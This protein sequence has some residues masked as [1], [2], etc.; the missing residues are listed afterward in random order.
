MIP[1]VVS[2]YSFRGSIIK[3]DALIDH[4][5]E[6]GLRSA[7]LAD[8]NFHGAV[9]FNHA[10]RE[11]GKIPIHALIKGKKVF[12]A[13]NREGF[14]SLVRFYNGVSKNMKSVVVKDI[15]S[16]KVV[17][18]LLKEH[19][20][21][22]ET[23]RKILKL[24]PIEGDFSM[25]GNMRDPLDIFKIEDYSLEVGQVFKSPD[26]PWPERRFSDPNY[27]KR[28]KRELDVVKRMGLTGYFHAVERIVRKAREMDV[29]V[30]PGR[31]SAVGSLLVY[32][33]GIT[34]V[35]PMKYG[36]M[37][38]RFLNE[39]RKEMPDIDI[40]IE[41]TKRH[42]LIKSLRD[43]FG[44]VALVS[45]FATLKEKSLR[46]AMKSLKLTQRGVELVRGL[47][48]KRS[49]HAAGVVVSEKPLDLP[50]IKAEIPIIEYDMDSLK[51]IGVEKIDLLG[52][53]TLSLLRE[54]EEITGENVENVIPERRVFESI[55][56][57]LTTGVFQLESL[58]AREIARYVMPSSIS[59]LSHLLAFNRPGPLKIKA[60][61]EYLMH[62][63]GK[64]VDLPS[65]L[66][67][68]LGET[69]GLP[70]YQEQITTMVS[71]LAGFSLE[72]A[73]DI[74]RAIS[75]KDKALLSELLPELERR[76]SKRYDEN[77]VRITLDLIEKFASYAFNKSHSVAYAHMSYWM[78]Y[79]K[80]HHFSE[81]FLAYLRWNRSDVMKCFQIVQEAR[82]RGY[83]VR[84]PDINSPNGGIGGET[85]KLPI[86]LIKG[87]GGSVVKTLEKITPIERLS[88][89]KFL[90]PSV[91]ENLIKSGA[92]DSIY[93]S[94]REALEILRKGEGAKV[95]E[96]LKSKMG[97]LNEKRKEE[98]LVDR[99]LM[100][101]DVLGF[102]VTILKFSSKLPTLSEVFAKGIKRAVHVLSL[103]KLISDG[104]TTVL[105]KRPLG[106]GERLI[107][108]KPSGDVEKNVIFHD[109]LRVFYELDLNVENFEKILEAGF[110]MENVK[111]G[112]KVIERSRPKIET[113]IAFG[114][115]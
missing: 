102:P 81:F 115:I 44:F 57:G 32:A 35:D 40:D 43:V 60:H 106:D 89:L 19:R 50:L 59:E 38:E 99:I 105:M 62:R 83:D 108:M 52:L 68:I 111:V 100:E 113:E 34:S 114:K 39:G 94:R 41:D 73:D 20:V 98:S 15:S 65:E 10:M 3:F 37:F 13:L 72:E 1:L 95:M 93:G 4:L 91:V 61:R 85:L 86:W 5:D 97:I 12:L 53:R 75:K 67:E 2:P 33:L 24:K 84:P 82:Y 29:K 71:K 92:L 6:L 88:D 22:F 74:R 64:K 36:L 103:G 101:S 23:M 58:E 70:V 28:L 80:E 47:P 18:Y 112:K 51:K 42:D 110:D 49:V 30:G 16:F 104:R 11:R 27:V 25:E 8:L 9:E 54:L 46:N 48:F 79:F 76:L 66:M 56:A 78:A 109:S 90:S 63:L 87:I 17:M 77:F 21:G 7:I 107:S 26:P 14:D 55:S 69:G 96:K 31:G 45:T